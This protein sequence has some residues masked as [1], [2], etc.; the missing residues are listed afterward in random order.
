MTPGEAISDWGALRQLLADRTVEAVEIVGCDRVVAFRDGGSPSKE[1]PIA[2]SDEEMIALIR[3]MVA[4]GDHRRFDGTSPELALRLADG[5][6]LVAL[7]AVTP[8][9]TLSIRRHP[10]AGTGGTV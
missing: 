2:A 9:P 6:R 1:E 7:M 4:P 3:G 5:T 8:R 10:V